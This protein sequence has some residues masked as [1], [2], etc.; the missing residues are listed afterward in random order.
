MDEPMSLAAP[1]EL[2]PHGTATGLHGVRQ[3]PR[4]RAGTRVRCRSRPDRLVGS[5]TGSVYFDPLHAGEDPGQLLNLVQM[6]DGA[7]AII[8]AR[9]DSTPGPRLSNTFFSQI[10]L[11]C[12]AGLAFSAGGSDAPV[13]GAGVPEFEHDYAAVRVSGPELF[14]HGAVVGSSVAR[15]R[16][17]GGG[18]CHPASGERADGGAAGPAPGP[19][20]T[21][22]VFVNAG[23]IGNTGPAAMWL[24]LAEL[25][26]RLDPG[27][28]MLALGAEATKFMFGGFSYVHG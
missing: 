26:S 6:G 10:G 3:C 25:R 4:H 20:E 14:D 13:L 11:G 9:D 16:C 7:A 19:R 12:K 28:R 18:P 21:R 5:E 22:R 27:A 15:C 1:A 17:R 23:R 2:A 8:L 24:A